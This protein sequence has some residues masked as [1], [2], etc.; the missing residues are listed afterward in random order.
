MAEIP[1]DD[2]PPPDE[3]ERILYVTVATEGNE[4]FGG[5]E[6]GYFIDNF[7]EMELELILCVVCKG[8]V[9]EACSSE[10]SNVCLVCL[11]DQSSFKPMLPVRTTVSKR[12][13]RCPLLRDCKWTGK[14]QEAEN[15]LG[16]CDGFLIPCSLGCG[17]V[18]KRCEAKSHIGSECPLRNVQ[19]KYCS[20]VTIAKEVQTHL[21]I[22]LKL[23]IQC[24]CLEKI[25]R[26]IVGKHIETECP[27]GE[28]QCPY[29]K[30]SCK[31][32]NM[33]RKDLLAHK[34][35][36]YI[37][38]QDMLE[39]ENKKMNENQLKLQEKLLLLEEAHLALENAH[40]ILNE[41]DSKLELRCLNLEEECRDLNAGMKIKKDLNGIELRIN[42]EDGNIIRRETQ[43]KIGS[44]SFCCYVTTIDPIKIT[45]RRLPT[46]T[47]NELNIICL[48]ES[49]IILSHTDRAIESY[50][51][52]N[53]LDLKLKVG[54]AEVVCV[55][56]RN[57]YDRYIQ[58]DRSLI[59]RLY[60]DL[61][62]ITYSYF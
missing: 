15:H 3:V 11:N 56:H 30:Y 42:P 41:K 28:V 18:V 57:V 58:R 20:I 33:H 60:F 34:Q 51:D 2:Y 55:L 25:S 14:L 7:T 61:E 8:I 53:R 27:F 46:R 48:T 54:E 5:Y 39:E 24:K 6:I 32:G 40:Q 44:Y 19:C 49:R 45:M 10:H 62:Y 35:A 16:E 1:S 50:L 31:I 23:P 29:A 4:T 17:K 47:R 22:C 26:D 36:F 38:H 43:F 13:I 12:E 59:V 9:R 52:V 37:E 21:N